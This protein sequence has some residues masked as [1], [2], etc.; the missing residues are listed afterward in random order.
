MVVFWTGINRI[1]LKFKD[2]KADEEADQRI[3]N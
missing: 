2:R 3:S 1:I